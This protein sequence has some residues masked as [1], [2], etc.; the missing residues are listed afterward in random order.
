MGGYATSVTSYTPK[1][2][3]VLPET[4]PSVPVVTRMDMPRLVVERTSGSDFRN[5]GRLEQIQSVGQIATAPAE[6]RIE[7]PRRPVINMLE[8]RLIVSASTGAKPAAASRNAAIQALD[9]AK[10]LI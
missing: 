1:S 6:R 10:P 2:A 9:A 5:L 8:N 7:I 3:P 4:T